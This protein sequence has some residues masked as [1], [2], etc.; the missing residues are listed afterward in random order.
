MDLSYE[1][2]KLSTVYSGVLDEARIVFFCLYVL[3][4]NVTLKCLQVQSHWTPCAQYEVWTEGIDS[5]HKL[6]RLKV[7]CIW[8]KHNK[9]QLLASV[10]HRSRVLMTNEL[11]FIRPMR[12][13]DRLRRHLLF[14]NK[15]TVWWKRDRS[16]NPQRIWIQYHQGYFRWKVWNYRHE[17]WRH[18]SHIR[19][20]LSR[21][22]LISQKYKLLCN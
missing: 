19:N 18:I 8:T 16:V 15:L 10:L 9:I 1:L 22:V 4:P 21:L 7:S 11:Q 14:R 12:K 2:C 20:L 5:L 13:D 17:V 6:Y 3:R